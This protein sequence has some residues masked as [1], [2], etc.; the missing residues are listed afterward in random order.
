MDGGG[1]NCRHQWVEVDS[2]EPSNKK[3]AENIIQE[4]KNAGTYHEPLTVR[5]Q[6]AV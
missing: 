2:A 4:R 3:N 6:L 5:E 1:Y